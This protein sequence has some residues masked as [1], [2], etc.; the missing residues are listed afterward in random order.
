MAPVY[1]T[2]ADLRAHTGDDAAALPD[3]RADSILETAEDAIDDALGARSVDATT[4]RKVAETDVEAWQWVKL[5]RAT[6]LAAARL[7]ADPGVLDRPIYADTSGPDFAFRGRVG[8]SGG[9]AD[10]IGTAAMLV[11]NASGLRRLGARAT[12]TGIVGRRE[13]G[14][15]YD[16]DLDGDDPDA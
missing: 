1:A 4:G 5:K 11:L 15:A 9:V 2:A 14:W 3:A 8:G 7:L 10:R 12:A 16:A 13:P 6:V